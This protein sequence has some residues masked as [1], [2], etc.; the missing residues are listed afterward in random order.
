MT[1]RERHPA[2]RAGRLAH[3]AVLCLVCL[4]L[5]GLTGGCSEDAPSGSVSTVKGKTPVV[6]PEDVHG[7]KGEGG[8]SVLAPDYR[9]GM[10]AALDA[11]ARRQSASAA[12]V[13]RTK[14]PAAAPDAGPTAGTPAPAVATQVAEAGR[15]SS[16]AGV[17]TTREALSPAT[18]ARPAGAQSEAGARGFPV[19]DC[20]QL[21]LVVAAEMGAQKGELRRFERQGATAPWREVG[22]EVSCWLG[23][24]GLGYGRGVVSMPPGPVKKQGDGRTPAG[25][26]PLP[27]AFGYAAPDKAGARLPYVAVTDRVACVTDPGASL[28]GRVVGPDERPEGGFVRQERMARDDRANLWGVVIGH[29]R[30]NPEPG[31]GSCVFVNVRPTGGPATGGSI[32]CPEAEAASLVGWLDPAASPVLAVLP[33]ALYKERRAAWGLP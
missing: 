22:Q 21:V 11:A 14:P 12:A 28:F 10:T 9:Q 32:G 18:G 16:G 20:R 33:R 3:A 7:G 30:D 1:W 24:K 8:T 25:F 23:R 13:S 5:A 15:P 19:A 29:N 2:A 26:F 6:R 27:Q 17:S 4:L 31:A